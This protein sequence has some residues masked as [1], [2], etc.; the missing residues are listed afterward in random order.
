VVLVAPCGFHLDGAV[1]QAR[2]V[3]ER[4]PGRPVW[5]LDG[6]GLVVRPGPRLVEGV[7]AIAGILHAADVGPP[8][9]TAAV[10]VA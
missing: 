5:A 6:D 9:D 1:D 7:E 10:R 3:A 8:P 2:V 4:L